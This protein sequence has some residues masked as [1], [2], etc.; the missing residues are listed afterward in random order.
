V[1][2][3]NKKSIYPTLPTADDDGLP[4]C[5]DEPTADRAQGKNYAAGSDDELAALQQRALLQLSAADGSGDQGRHAL[6]HNTTCF[7]MTISL[8]LTQVC[9]FKHACASDFCLF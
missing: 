4:P 6:P 5:A 2:T 8:S 7:S 3:I 9:F 1:D